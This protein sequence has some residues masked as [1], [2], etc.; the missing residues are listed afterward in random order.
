MNG[1]ISAIPASFVALGSTVRNT[2]AL[3]HTEVLTLEPPCAHGV[4][5][6]HS[7]EGLPRL[8]VSG[9]LLPRVGADVVRFLRYVRVLL[10]GAD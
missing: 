8:F 10:D 7:P 9:V 5:E 1:T 2:E 3:L 6:W 4:I